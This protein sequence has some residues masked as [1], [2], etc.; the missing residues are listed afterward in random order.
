METTAGQQRIYGARPGQP[1]IW[2]WVCLHPNANAILLV[3]Y[4]HTTTIEGPQISVKMATCIWWQ[5]KASYLEY[6]HMIEKNPQKINTNLGRFNNKDSVVSDTQVFVCL[7]V[8]LFVIWSYSGSIMNFT[9]KYFSVIALHN[10]IVNRVP[11]I[12]IE[13]GSPDSLEKHA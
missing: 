4:I 5:T 3:I 7:F 12:L 13:I 1:L 6:F 9:L 8:C 11:T 10:T 2:P